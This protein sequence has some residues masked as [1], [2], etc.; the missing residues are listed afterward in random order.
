MKK[1]MLFGSFFL[2]SFF[3]ALVGNKSDVQAD[4]YSCTVTVNC[5]GGSISCT[6]EETCSRSYLKGWVSCDGNVTNC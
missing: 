2:I 5:V 1:L 6:G 3:T 4:S